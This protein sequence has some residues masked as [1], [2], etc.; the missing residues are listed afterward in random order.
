MPNVYLLNLQGGLVF[1]PSFLGHNRALGAKL[2][3]L[4]GMVTFETVSRFG[5]MLFFFAIGVKMDPETMFHPERKA[6]EIGFSVFT[7]TLAIPSLLAFILAKY[8][9]MDSNLAKSLPVIAA[10]QSLTSFPVIAC[11]LSELKILNTDIGRLALSSAMFCDVLGITLTVTVLTF[12]GDQTNTII[13]PTLGIISTILF[14]AC[15]LFVFRPAIL[16]MR[17][18]SKDGKSVKEVYIFGSLV[19][20]LVTTFLC[21][22]IGQHYVLGPLILGLVVPNGPPLG[23]ALVSKVDTLATGLFYPTYLAVSGLQTNFYMV[24]LQGLLVVGIITFF[25]C[26][27]K[28]GAV[29]VTGYY[30][31]MPRYEAFVL[32]LILNGKGIIQLTVF[33][34]W[35]QNKVINLTY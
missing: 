11:L 9:P 27:I 32:G 35:R 5:L 31:N 24:Q 16:W 14:I 12:V 8:L 10:S 28:V 2:F 22:G 26:I 25:A 33:N 20:L 21:E 6:M 18:R 34:L 4:R 29:M 7:L 23:A 19:L 3:P 1:G 17:N 30:T 13:M 15:V